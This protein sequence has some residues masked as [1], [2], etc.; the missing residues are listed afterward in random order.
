MNSP[1]NKQSGSGDRADSGASSDT[2][3][4]QEQAQ[5]LQGI[6][7]TL[8]QEAQ[9]LKAKAAFLERHADNLRKKAARIAPSEAAARDALQGGNE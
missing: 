9:R 4:A 2:L 1:R 3:A 8:M 7:R 5:R 6:A